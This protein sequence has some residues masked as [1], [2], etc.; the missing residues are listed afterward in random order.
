MQEEKLQSEVGKLS[1]LIIC[2]PHDGIARILPYKCQDWLYE[3]IIDIHE[4]RKEYSLFVRILLNF[5]DPE[6][7][8]TTKCQNQADLVS[9]SDPTSSKYF[10]SDKVMD[11]M[12]LLIDI[13]EKHDDRVELLSA[14]AT[15]ESI[16]YKLYRDL[17]E[18]YSS[19]ELAY[20]LITGCNKEN[21]IIIPPIPNIIMARDIVAFINDHIIIGRPCMNARKRE[22]VI[23]YSI[24]NHHKIFEHYINRNS[25]IY[26]SESS[27][28]FMQSESEIEQYRMAL[29]C[30]DILVVSKEHVLIGISERT[31]ALAA[32]Q[33]VTM[34]FK[35][36]VVQKASII[37]LPKERFCM[38]LDTV[39]TQV[40]PNMWLVF[41]PILDEVTS[42]HD[43]THKSLKSS[44]K[45]FQYARL[46]D[47]SVSDPKQFKSLRTLI[48]NIS[49][50]E[51]GY[52]HVDIVLCGDGKFPDNWR[53]QWT[54]GCNSFAVKPGVIFLYD[55]NYKTIEALKNK[56]N[57]N[58]IS[59]EQLLEKLDSNE[60][61]CDKITDTVIT[62]K[63]A[64]LSRA[65][66]GPHCLTLPISR[67]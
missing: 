21:I 55:R 31:S 28:I 3:D 6:F 59:A 18:N 4:A 41:D 34:L 17:V 52:D 53:E 36:N 29:E 57:F 1:K 2:A 44:L 33:L 35:N 30:G 10:R 40:K 43:H 48:E 46:Y 8:S 60:L 5:V 65:R 38:H 63:S 22:N 13:L 25:I 24:I 15:S 7:Y 54:D 51:L 49:K 26:L 56:H 66:G 16:P 50:Q 37:H 14:V 12:W 9:F 45:I 62:L 58:V 32:N 61:K 42:L 47:G 23:M 67:Y 27:N 19:K 20:F 11:V 39:L 64:E